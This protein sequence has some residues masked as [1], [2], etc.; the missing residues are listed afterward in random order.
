MDGIDGASIPGACYAARY[1]GG[2]D[3]RAQEPLLSLCAPTV[4]PS[5]VGCWPDIQ[6]ALERTTATTLRRPSGYFEAA[7]RPPSALAPVA[8]DTRT[9]LLLSRVPPAAAG[10]RPY[11]SLMLHGWLF[12]AFGAQPARKAH[13]KFPLLGVHGAANLA[14]LD[15]AAGRDE[16][17]YLSLI[18]I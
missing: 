18:H 17:Q 9:H 2:D 14:P 16:P 4:P 6:A 3:Y 10:E 12:S 8:W 7:L 1:G 5:A 15:A 13:Q 11:A